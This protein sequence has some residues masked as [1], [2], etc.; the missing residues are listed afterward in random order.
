MACLQTCTRNHILSGRKEGGDPSIHSSSIYGLR[1]VLQSMKKR[2]RTNTRTD[3]GV[4]VESMD[5]S[6][7]NYKEGTS[8]T[9]HTS[10]Y[11]R[12]KYVELP[13]G[14]C[15]LF[16]KSISH[17]ERS[18]IQIRLPVFTDLLTRMCKPNSVSRVRFSTSYNDKPAVIQ[19]R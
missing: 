5:E 2:L 7:R 4:L 9:K 15:L 16:R 17:V 19:Y 6:H 1:A 12:V 11:R 8:S 13:L 18:H 3:S 10:P 14:V